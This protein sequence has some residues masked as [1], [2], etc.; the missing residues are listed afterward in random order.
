MNL[1]E[2]NNTTKDEVLVIKNGE[3]T[4]VTLP[5]TTYKSEPI[6]IITEQTSLGLKVTFSFLKAIPETAIVAS[7]NI[8]V[9]GELHGVKRIVNAFTGL[10]G[11][12]LVD[13]MYAN[14]SI[15]VNI[16]MENNNK[17]YKISDEISVV[18]DS[19]ISLNIYEPESVFID[20]LSLIQEL[21][22][23]MDRLDNRVS[24]VE[25]KLK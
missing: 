13:S 23:R 12:V 14:P 11:V 9:Y 10:Q 6:S 24:V 2:Y 3:S 1:T 19:N 20:Q 22:K 17:I 7:K 4:M 5:E 15:S 25:N 18:T 21:V 16:E 8:I